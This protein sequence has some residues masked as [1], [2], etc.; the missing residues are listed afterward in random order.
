MASNYHFTKEE[1]QTVHPDTLLRRMLSMTATLP[2][3]SLQDLPTTQIGKGQ[4]GTIT[5]FR[6]GEL[7]K[8]TPN[9]TE[10]IAELRDEYWS[11]R[12]VCKAFHW[13]PEALSS[14]AQ[15][16]RLYN[17]I[18][19]PPTQPGDDMNEEHDAFLSEY[20]YTGS[21]EVFDTFFFGTPARNMP[22]QAYKQQLSGTPSLAL[23]HWK[24]GLD[25]N[26]V[27]FVLGD[28]VRG[29]KDRDDHA[30]SVWL[31]DFNQCR[32]FNHD[33]AGLKQLVDGFWWNDPYYPRP[34][35]SHPQD[36][37][38]WNTF[39]SK[40]LDASALLTD[41]KMPRQFIQAVEEE[42]RL[43]IYAKVLALLCTSQR[44]LKSAL[45]SGWK[46]WEQVVAVWVGFLVKLREFWK[47]DAGGI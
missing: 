31:L 1:C 6:R 38:W 21:A 13:P 22:E 20:G 9:S 43:F 33:Q 32:R 4:C 28:S 3:S 18:P 23:M 15:V 8:K 7:V 17:F 46:H 45:G 34:G 27:E 47:S 2:T 14:L 29:G 16:P 25:A 11:H 30:V 24:V 39:L 10:K 19:L 41:S 35:A 44:C 12:D 5:T 40:Y 36:K 37:V 42:V 26:D